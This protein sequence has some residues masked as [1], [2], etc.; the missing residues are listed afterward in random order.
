MNV[1]S[2]HDHD[3]HEKLKHKGL[4]TINPS[5]KLRHHSLTATPHM[6]HARD[7]CSYSI[8]FVDVR[9]EATDSENNN[10]VVGTTIL[11]S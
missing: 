6:T 10:H 9:D 5:E 1:N 7:L 11:Y 8:E 2:P 4:L 3:T